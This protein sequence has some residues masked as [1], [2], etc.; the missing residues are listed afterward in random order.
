MKLKVWDFQHP[1]SQNS[2]QGYNNKDSVV[3]AK[4]GHIYQWKNNKWNNGIINGKIIN[5]INPHNYGQFISDKEDK[6]IQWGKE[7][8]LQQIM[9]G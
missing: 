5:G 6:T 8:S 2:S 1:W 4:S 9:L 7:Q 3:V